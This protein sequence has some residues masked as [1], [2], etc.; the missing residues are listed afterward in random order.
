MKNRQFELR[1]RL[2]R[3]YHRNKR[4][5]QFEQ[6][7]LVRHD[8]S[9]FDPNELSWWDDV[10]FILG[11]LRV[12]VAWQHPRHV[13]R[14]MI[15]DAAMRAAHHLYE[16]IDADLFAGSEKSYKKVGRSRKK[17]QSYTTKSRPGAQEWLDAVRA[18]EARLSKGSEFSVVPSF[19][20]KTLA[21]CRFVEI[22]AP[23][24]VRNVVELRMLADLVRRILKGETT[25]A[26][27]FPGYVYDK[28]RWV[29]EELVEQ[30]LYVVSHQI[31]GT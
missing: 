9:E 1:R 2:A 11:G 4:G 16:K 12:A 29:S 15:E 3:Q 22:V 23:V 7:I 10:Q 14:G 21:W 26:S 18:E 30:P 24:E 27:E 8:Y 25:L 31:A 28:A 13:Y 17:I 20:V 5:H 19:K 6:G